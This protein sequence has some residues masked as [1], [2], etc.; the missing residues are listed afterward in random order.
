MALWAISD[1]HLALNMNKPMDIFGD[2]WYKH[3]EKIER[4]WIDSVSDDD[5]VLIAGDISWSMKMEDGMVDLEWIHNLPGEKILIRGNHDYWWNSITKLN[6]LYDD[7][8]FIQNNFFNYQDYAICGT[9][10]WNCPGSANFTEHDEKIYN[11][12]INRLRLSLDSAVK[13]GY[14]KIIVMMHYPP[15]NDKSE[16]TGFID[17][18]NE[19]KVKKVIYGHLHGPSLNNLF[20]GVHSNIE[21]IV[22]SADYLDFKPKLINLE[23]S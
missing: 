6:N 12:E 11:R 9:R 19:Y 17:V 13:N 10:G 16:N 7:M 1:L 8:H 2:N 20:E 15:I 22:T 14:E 4:N 23:D 5:T 3:E 21:Y 18:F